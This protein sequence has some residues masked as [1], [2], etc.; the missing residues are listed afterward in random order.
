MLH[1][2]YV[3]RKGVHLEKDLVNELID[4]AAL[5]FLKPFGRCFLQFP[6]LGHRVLGL[7]HQLGPDLIN[8]RFRFG[9]QRLILLRRH[10]TV[11]HHGEYRDS[12]WSKL[13][14]EIHHLASLFQTAHQF[15]GGL[16]VGL[17]MGAELVFERLVAQH[18]GNLC[19]KSP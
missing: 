3:L 13:N 5:Q 7:L 15:L 1:L 16:A 6:N 18:L 2:R 4:G 12:I 14:G 11:F 10:G 8:R 17:L 9:L 19:L